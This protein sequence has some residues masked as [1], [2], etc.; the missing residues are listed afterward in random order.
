MLS[1]MRITI[2]AAL[3]ISIGFLFAQN[4]ADDP[5]GW[6]KAKWGMTQTD[7]NMAFPA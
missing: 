2:I 1:Q 6:S 7:I 5:G 4:P 3:A